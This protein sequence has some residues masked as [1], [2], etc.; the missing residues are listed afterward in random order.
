MHSE[1]LQI[2]YSSSRVIKSR[3]VKIDGGCSMHGRNTNLYKILIRSDDV[4]CRLR[5]DRIL[6]RPCLIR[7]RNYKW[8]R[9]GT[10]TDCDHWADH[11]DFIMS[12]CWVR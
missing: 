12:N 4:E 11:S 8:L 3:S 1:E 6:N 5:S 2:L 9:K 10:M 7:W